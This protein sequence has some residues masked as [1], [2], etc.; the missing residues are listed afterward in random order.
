MERRFR[1][2]TRAV[3]VAILVGLCGADLVT[4]YEGSLPSTLNP[5]FARSM[6]DR[7]VQELVFDRL[8]HRSSFTGEVRSH[9]VEQDEVLD[10]GLAIRLKIRGGIRWHDGE[11]LTAADL[12]FSVNVLLDEGTPSQTAKPFREIL[13]GCEVEDRRTARISFRRRL[14]NPKEQLSFHVLPQHRF[15]STAVQPDSD[16]SVRPVGT[17]PLAGRKG[18]TE[19]YLDA[20]DNAHHEAL[21]REARIAE[22][23]DPLVQVRTLLNSGVQGLIAVAPPLRPDVIHSDDVVLKSY[24]LRSWWFIAVNQK[25]PALKDVHVRRAIDAALDREDLR[26]LALGYDPEDPMPPCEFISGPFVPSSPYYNRLVPV[27]SRSDLAG[28]REQ[29]QAAGA[30][31][32]HGA[33][34]L[35]G[36]RISLRIG[37]HAPLDLEA[38][39]LL[40]LVGNQL[41]VAGF[42]R[43]VHKVSQDV[44]TTHA[45]TGA[46]A[47]EYDLLIGKWS[48]GVVENV[49]P[50]FETRRGGRGS[51]NIFGGSDPVVDRLVHD[52]EAAVTIGQA[53][54]AYHALHVRLASEKPYIFLWK[55]DTKS[56]WR[57]EMKATTITPYWYFTEFDGWYHEPSAG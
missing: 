41:Q 51:L 27:R 5:L 3:V 17:G 25:S 35:D 12:C 38:K 18:R 47:D 33:W 30:T 26:A 14:R 52:W 4:W 22:G 15:D 56:A 9:L 55:L 1:V 54:A 19:V 31:S 40:N 20:Y 36:E 6:V 29:M 16:F 2:L 57:N 8:Y 13:E 50:M 11:R 48:F 23:G 49:G 24:D 43:E 39:D 46:L 7:R 53:Q 21:V 45:V 34:A 44:W 37:M 10:G 42:G 28:V 32:V